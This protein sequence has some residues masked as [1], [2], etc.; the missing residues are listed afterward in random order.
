MALLR[1]SGAALSAVA[2]A[3]LLA[4]A[5]LARPKWRMGL[6]ERLGRVPPAGEDGAIWVH[7]AS[8]GEASAALRL[9]DVLRARGHPVRA[10]TT[11]WTGRGLFAGARPS[12]TTHL[13]PLDH[14]YPVAA[15]LARARPAA[16]VMVETELWPSWIAGAHARGIPVA[17]ASGRLSDVTFPRYRRLGRLFARTFARLA[18][19]GARSEEDA[20]RFA[21][22]GVPEER[23][24]V[25]GDLKL[26]PLAPGP[27]AA[28]LAAV[29]GPVPLLAAGSVHPGEVA[30][31]L[32]AFAAVRAAGRSAALLLAP[33]HPERFD[34][35]GRTVADAGLV[36][37]RRSALTPDPLAPGEVLL[38]DSVGEL[39]ALYGRARSAF[40]GGSLVAGV[41]GHNV[42]EPVFAG[43]PVCFGP[44]T[45]DAR[46]AVRIV[47]AAG[48]GEC[49]SD[50]K[51]LARVFLRDL[52]DVDDADA[53]G[54][55][56]R[57]ALVP[58]EGAGR[59]AADC[60]EGLLAPSRRETA[61]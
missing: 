17:I 28:D 27:L 35:I 11:T 32:E 45:R 18:A 58:H 34:E 21:A 4:L 56:G 38:L 5:W 51:Q 6:A 48:A 39:A 47:L 8:V 26:E 40:V 9:V 20:R 54:A 46:E 57:A 36:L 53:R 43:R 33:R 41:G 16:L 14:P 55:A 50:A 25:T 15:A 19:V 1:R 44:G 49:V 7:A 23:I 3:P 13:A 31:L 60:I 30:P 52:D 29:L 61:S 37:R 42:L 24:S 10:S 22:L 12:L 2:A 59:R